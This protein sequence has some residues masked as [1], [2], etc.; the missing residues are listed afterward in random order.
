MEC[1]GGRG[2]KGSVAASARTVYVGRLVNPGIQV[3]AEVVIAL[4]KAIAVSAVMVFGALSVVLLTRVGASKVTATIITRPVNIGIPFVLLQGKV[5][6]E[7]YR[8][9]I[10]IRHWHEMVVVGYEEV[11]EEVKA[12]FLNL[13]V[14]HM[15]HVRRPLRESYKTSLDQIIRYIHHIWID[16]T[17]LAPN[18]SSIIV[19]FMPPTVIHLSR[20]SKSGIADVIQYQTMSS[21]R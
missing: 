1:E 18:G 14:N 19:S 2:D 8:A 5:S 11:C 6:R 9:A 13:Y 15:T 3:L 7:P 10:T 16:S 21:T 4:E 12:R 17:L 20:C